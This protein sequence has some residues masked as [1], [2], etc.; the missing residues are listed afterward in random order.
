MSYKIAVGSRDGK[1]VTEHFGGCRRFLI[2]EA[3]SEHQ[4]YTFKEFREVSPPCVEGEHSE[5]GLSAVAQALSDCRLVLVGKIGPGAEV[6][7]DRCGIDVLEYHGPI[8]DAMKRILQYY[9]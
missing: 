3:D 4:T 8:D 9:K 7:L 2:L 6:L 1:M 5:N